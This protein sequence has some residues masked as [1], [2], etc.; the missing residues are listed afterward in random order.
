MPPSVSE[1]LR[2]LYFNKAPKCIQSAAEL[3][4]EIG[5]LVIQLLIGDSIDGCGG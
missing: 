3:A 1:I 5:M 4:M 2:F